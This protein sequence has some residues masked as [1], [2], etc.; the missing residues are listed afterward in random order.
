MTRLTVLGNNIVWC[1]RKSGFDVIIVIV[2]PSCG[3]EIR[4]SHTPTVCFVK[5]RKT[6]MPCWM[7]CG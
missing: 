2:L 7:C 4:C 6:G 5:R 1:L 3:D